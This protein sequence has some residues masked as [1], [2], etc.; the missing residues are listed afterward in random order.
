MTAKNAVLQLSIHEER[1]RKKALVT[2]S[3]FSGVTSITMDKS[4]K[5]TIVGEVDV[6]AVVMKLRKLCNTEIVSVDDVKPPVKKPEPEK[7]A[8]SIAYPVPM[9][10]AYQF[11]PAYANSYYHQPY[12]NCRVV[13]EPN[14]VIM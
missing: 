8:E 10:Y 5:M 7:P 11:N 13:D 3:R 9:N 4:G 1:T 14:C 6:P 12:G 2:V